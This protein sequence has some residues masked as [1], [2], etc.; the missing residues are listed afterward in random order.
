MFMT[1][2]KKYLVIKLSDG[3]SIAYH[4]ELSRGVFQSGS[5]YFWHSLGWVDCV[6]KFC[7]FKA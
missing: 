7:I 1:F 6:K 5:N 4:R 2:S 3:A